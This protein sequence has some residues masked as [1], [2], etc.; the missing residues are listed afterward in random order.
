[1]GT[2]RPGFGAVGV[3]CWDGLMLDDR[4]ERQA[5]FIFRGWQYAGLRQ[6]DRAV[7]F[8]EGCVV[9]GGVRRVGNAFV[10]CNNT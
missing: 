6:F 10:L 3:M 7:A 4:L 5:I 9:K 2:C 8:R 1:M